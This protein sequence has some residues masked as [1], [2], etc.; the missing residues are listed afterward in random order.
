[1]TLFLYPFFQ[2]LL[3]FI[4]IAVAYTITDMPL[5]WMRILKFS[6]V[7]YLIGMTSESLG[8][9]ISSQLNVV[10]RTTLIAKR[11]LNTLVNLVFKKNT[12][13]NLV[14]KYLTQFIFDLP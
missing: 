3:G 13:I 4:Y 9:A 5:E 14:L 11:F 7:C 12:L 1:M 6:A 2:F 10:V 8:F